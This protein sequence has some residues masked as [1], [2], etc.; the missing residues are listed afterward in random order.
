V[1]KQSWIMSTGEKPAAVTIEAK[2]SNQVQGP[3]SGHK[4]SAKDGKPC[5]Q[6]HNTLEEDA[7]KSPHVTHH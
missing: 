3:V 5:H 1:N 2:R 6:G 7:C 4:E